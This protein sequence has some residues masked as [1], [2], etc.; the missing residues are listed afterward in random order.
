GGGVGASGAG[1][2]VEGG[3]GGV[4]P[5]AAGRHR[6][7]DHVGAGRVLDGVDHPGAGDAD[8]GTAEGAG[9]GIDAVHA[10]AGV[11]PAVAVGV[12]A[13]QRPDGETVFGVQG[14]RSGERVAAVEAGD[15][16]NVVVGRHGGAGDE[17]L[18]GVGE[19]V[20]DHGAADGGVGRVLAPGGA[21]GPGGALG[22]AV[23]DGAGGVRGGARGGGGDALA[24]G[25]EGRGGPR[26]PGAGPADLAGQ[27]G[28]DR[29]VGGQ[30]LDVSGSR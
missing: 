11:G 23:L 16:D 1:V 30:Q 7:V 25:V 24:H 8:E 27:R 15:H 28:D 10:S 26:G 14:I 4:G 22:A 17:R 6:G 9:E 29:Q 12:G 5:V 21:A 2:G 3:D 13:D 18:D 20:D 19:R